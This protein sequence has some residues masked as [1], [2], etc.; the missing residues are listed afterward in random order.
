[1]IVRNW[2]QPNPATVSPGTLLS[3]A[4]Q[5]LS[6]GNLHALPVLEDE[7]LR[8]L[9]TRAHCVRAAGFVAR[10]Q[11]AE[12]FAYFANKLTV[13]DLMVRNP[14]T[15][16]A[17]DTVEHCLHKGRQ[18]GVGQF[19]V[20]EGTRLAG[21]ISA[22]EILR[23]AGQLIGAMEDWCGITLVP[24]DLDRG[25]LGRIAATAERAGASL[26]ALYPLGERGADGRAEG[27]PGRIILRFIAAD[28]SAVADALQAAGF[29]VLE[30]AAR[31]QTGPAEPARERVSIVS[32]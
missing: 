32:S 10:T 2:M 13:A 5:I 8:G 12:E 18:L 28:L 22:R 17:G 31:V 27:L 30:S 16:Q 14:A 4:K 19:P 21:L 29:T 7:R 25:T 23:L 3:E 6:A 15:I 26:R 11:S 1:M 20:L 9:L 24:E